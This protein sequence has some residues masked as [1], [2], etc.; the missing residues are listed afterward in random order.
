MVYEGSFV[1]RGVPNEDVL[2]NLTSMGATVPVNTRLTDDKLKIHQCQE[3]LKMYFKNHPSLYM[4]G[5][6]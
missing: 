3:E 5:S 1:I 2:L 4:I 6:S